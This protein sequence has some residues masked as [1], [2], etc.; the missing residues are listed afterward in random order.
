M[1][2]ICRRKAF[3][4][5]QTRLK[6]NFRFHTVLLSEALP[7]RH[8]RRRRRRLPQRKSGPAGLHH[9]LLQVGDRKLEKARAD[10]GRLDLH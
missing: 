10:E 3:V 6:V 8:E 4:I 7:P 9:Q 2:T 1:S 5:T